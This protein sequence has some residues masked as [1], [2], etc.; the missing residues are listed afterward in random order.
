MT[1]HQKIIILFGLGL[2][3]VAC[4]PQEIGR[5]RDS[6]EYTD[7]RTLSAANE[8]DAEG[9]FIAAYSRIAG[10]DMQFRFDLLD[11]SDT[12]NVDIYL[13]IDTKPGGTQLLPINGSSEIEWDTLLILPAFDTPRA[14]SSS[15]IPNSDSDP[16]DEPIFSLQEDLVP[17]VIRIPWQDYVV[18][19]VNKNAIPLTTK[20]IKI[21]AFSSPARSSLIQDSIGPFR[22]TALPPQPAPVILAFWNT[23]PAYTPAQSLRRWD[24]AHT[25]PFGERHGLSILLNNVKRYRVPTILLDLRNPPVLS[26]L[27]HMGAIPLIN[28]LVSDK[29]LVLPDSIP[30]SP[31]FPIFPTGLPDWAVIQYLQDLK[32]TSEMYGLPSSDLFYTPHALEGKFN[33]YS[34]IFSPNESISTTHLPNRI[35]LPVPHQIPNEF[36]AMPDGLSITVRRQLLDNAL[37]INHQSGGIPLLILGGS[38][39]DN[40]FG[41]P[42]SSAATFS[43][44]AN[45]PWIKPIDGDDLSTLTYLVIPQTVTGTT[46]LTTIESFSPSQIL[47]GFSKP[48]AQ[49]ENQSY[50]A[51]WQSALSLFDPLPPEPDNLPALR[52]IY[53]GQ[54]G[55]LLEAANWANKPTP[56]RDCQSDADLDGTPECV[57]ASNNQFAIFDLEGARLIAYFYLSDSE[58]H[59]II[60]PT[61]QFV[62]GLGDPS[63]WQLDYREGADTTG[64]HGAFIESSPPWQLY[65]VGGSAGQLT[66]SSPDQSIIKEFSMTENG[67][68]IEINGIDEINTQIPVAIDPWKRYLPGWNETYDYDP[69]PEGF[70]FR[71]NDQLVFKVLTDSLISAWMF[72]DSSK[73]LS[74]PE[75]PNFDYPIGHYLPYPMALLELHGQRNLSVEFTINSE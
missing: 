69:I 30:G 29:L 19:S 46:D 23:F 27:D 4:S 55:I 39:A 21:Q 18:I 58:L 68:I 20:G 37:N 24:G 61:S 8:E 42:S 45:H 10:S 73:Y 1:N 38:L 54:P 64:I 7:L 26:A 6:W 28:E 52:A 57:L 15:S 56:R 41:D 60:A 44:I 2:L 25:G 12:P 66:F 47:E 75:D 40:A 9:D 62:V 74:A 14:L 50:T 72:T 33:G 32:T 67:L 48:S 43:Y 49:L 70:L 31:T 34:L 65:N 17:R 3:I 16:N 35:T 36:Q 13:A 22:T 59:Q 51:A 5:P 53:S 63:S 71:I 11:L